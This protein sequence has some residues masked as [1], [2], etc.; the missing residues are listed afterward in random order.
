MNQFF[1]LVHLSLFAL[2]GFTLAGCEEPSS[3]SLNE[4]VLE[5]SDPYVEI[6]DNSTYRSFSEEYGSCP[7]FIV[8]IEPGSVFNAWVCTTSSCSIADEVYLT[9]NTLIVE[10]PANY[11]YVRLSVVSPSD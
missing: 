3:D 5:D 11:D 6:P 9:D 1:V 10:C 8:D 2:A 4:E 7:E